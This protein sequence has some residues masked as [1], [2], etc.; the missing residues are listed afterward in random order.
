MVQ[1]R[2]AVVEIAVDEEKCRFSLYDPT[3]CKRCLEVCPLAIFATRPIQKRDFSVPKEQRVDPTI[4]M[5]VTPWRD[6]CDGCGACLRACAHGA[7]TITFDGV[8]VE[9]KAIGG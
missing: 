6:Y 3:G 2:Q 7:I 9:A 4:W 1:E 5:M 8:P